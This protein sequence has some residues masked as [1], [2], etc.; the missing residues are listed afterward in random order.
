MTTFRKSSPLL[1][2]TLLWGTRR[3][4]GASVDTL[5]WEN[6]HRSKKVL[7]GTSLKQRE[8]RN[9]SFLL[10]WVLSWRPYQP[11][12]ALGDLNN[13]LTGSDC[14][15]RDRSKQ[16]AK[17]QAALVEAFLVTFLQGF[18]LLLGEFIVTLKQHG[19]L[20]N[21]LLVYNCVI[22]FNGEYQRVRHIP[23]GRACLLR[24][25]I[26]KA[27]TIFIFLLFWSISTHNVNKFY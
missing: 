25:W 9:K 7:E 4:V 10:L 8:E 24:A 26:R 18:H 23:Y 20:V 14:S 11:S 19:I 3:N 17:G 1:Q 21:M 12:N 15:V 2:W 13:C 6:I 16:C 5:E 27:I 22:K